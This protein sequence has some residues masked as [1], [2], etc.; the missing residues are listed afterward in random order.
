MLFE[1]KSYPDRMAAVQLL[2][3]MLFLAELTFAKSRPVF[4]NFN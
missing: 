2:R 3:Y 1:H 4:Y